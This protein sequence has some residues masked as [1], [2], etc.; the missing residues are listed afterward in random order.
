MDGLLILDI[1]ETCR[2]YMHKVQLVRM[3]SISL[4]FSRLTTKPGKTSLTTTPFALTSS[5]R[6]LFQ[7]ARKA[8]DAE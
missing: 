3:R 4:E 1:F 5:P 2:V 6:A 7:V 8:F